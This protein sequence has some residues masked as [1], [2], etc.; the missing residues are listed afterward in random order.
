MQRSVSVVVPSVN[1]GP[2]LL[3]LVTTVLAG[4]QQM[5]EVIVADN[6]LPRDDAE[7]LTAAG[8]RVLAMGSNLGFGA[9]VNRAAAAAEGE[10]LVIVN[11]DVVLLEGFVEN[12]VAPLGQGVDMV[13]GVLLRE[14]NPDVIETAGIVVDA[15]FS[16]Y[17]HL[18][19]QPVDVLDADPPP[20]L[21][22][23]GGAA[24]YDRRRFLD[25][26]GFDENLFAYGEDLDLAMRL[27]QAGSA[28]ALAG[29][30]R[31]VHTGSGTLGYHT[32]AK[33]DLVGYSRGYLLRKY[34]V[35]RRPLAGAR[36]VAVEAAASAVL[37]KRHR[38]PSPALA[39]VRGW[40]ECN[41]TATGPERSLVTVGLLEGLRSRYARSVP[42]A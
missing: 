30:A 36:A 1:G 6:G 37:A 33:A 11:D 39:R 16:A 24:A 5:T 20:P 10:A 7:A 9:A 42:R 13:A 41:V 32:L 4:P 35:L 26:G 38:S 25:V 18:Q 15:V 22:P 28:C 21:G 31:A 34:G 19:D 14:T 8:A 12:I 2:R 23:C 40:R 3:E 29:D 27:R 17:D